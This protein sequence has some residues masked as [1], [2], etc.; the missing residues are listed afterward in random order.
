MHKEFV[1]SSLESILESI[2][3]IEARLSSIKNADDFMSTPAVVTKLDSI[4]MRLQIIGELLKKIDKVDSNYLIKFRQVEW[5]KIIK[6]RDIISHHYDTINPEIVFDVCQNHLPVLKS[7]LLE[8]I[9][10]FQ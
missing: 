5:E 1:Q 10:E 9:K 4:S 2:E 6:M 8:M 7:T 3:I